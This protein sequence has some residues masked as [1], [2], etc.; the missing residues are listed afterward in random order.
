MLIAI[1]LD[2]P[3]QEAQDLV[4]QP[5]QFLQEIR[6]VLEDKKSH[7]ILERMLRTIEGNAAKGNQQQRTP[8]LHGSLSNMQ[9][10]VAHANTV[11][12]TVRQNRCH[13]CG[14]Q[15]L[16]RAPPLLMRLAALSIHG[17]RVC[18]GIDSFLVL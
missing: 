17:E 18:P 10:L 2:R 9:P 11:E 4:D 5:Y 6:Q 14:K 12:Y 1:V 3:L 13:Y 15:A 7:P 8:P 16:G